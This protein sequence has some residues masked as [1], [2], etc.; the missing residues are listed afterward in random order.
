[1]YRCARQ[2]VFRRPKVQ[3]GRVLQQELKLLLA[4]VVGYQARLVGFELDQRLAGRPV[5]PVEELFSPSVALVPPEASV[6][7]RL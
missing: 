5:G 1:M 3:A 6:G 7:S 4:E 2:S